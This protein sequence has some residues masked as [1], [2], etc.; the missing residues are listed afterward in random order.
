MSRKNMKR[1]R[2]KASGRVQGIFFRVKA[3]QIAEELNLVGYARNLDDGSVEVVAEG[4]EEK[5]NEL[6]DWCHKGPEM[7]KV[8]KVE[9]SLGEATFEFKD[10]QVKY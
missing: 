2:I 4:D 1:I 10:F 8:T 5:L 7:A 3:Q 6:L 9:S